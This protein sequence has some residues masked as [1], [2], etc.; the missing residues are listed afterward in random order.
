MRA[1][2]AQR[3]VVEG[4]G[5]WRVW[6]RRPGHEPV[7]LTWFRGVPTSIG[8][9]TDGDPYG[10]LSA[11]LTF[12]KVTIF[13]RLGV[14]E[15]SWAAPEVDFDIVWDGPLPAAYPYERF[16][17]EGFS[18]PF[19]RS[20]DGGLEVT[21]V[22]AAME[23]D[24]FLAKPE[25]PSQPLPY[26]VA[27]ARQWRGRPS[28]RLRQLK[29]EFPSWWTT[30]Y[31]PK[32]KERAPYIP[33]GVTPGQRWTG[34]LTRETGS[35]DKALTSYI[36]TMLTSMYTDRG[37]WT[38]DLRPGRRPVLLH[39]DIVLEA[40]P[41]TVV[42][43][44]LTPG[45]RIDLTEDWSQTA[46]VVYAQTKSLSGEAFSGMQVVDD[47]QGTVYKPAAALRQVDPISDRNTWLQPERMRREQM[48]QLQ[49]G[50]NALDTRAVAQKHLQQI[51]EPGQSGTVTLSADP[52]M[53]GQVLPRLCIKAGMTLQ[54]RNYN[55]SPDG[56]LVHV[57]QV[58]A[59][60]SSGQVT[61]TVDS[62]FRDRLTVDEVQLRGRDALAVQRMLIGGRYRP[63]LPDDLFPWNYAEG[64][65]YIP[66]SPTY[67]ARRLF[68]D[69]PP[70]V[71]FPWE[72]W[73]RTRPPRSAS[74]KSSYIRIAPP[75]AN[76]DQNWAYVANRGGGRF[77]FPIRLAQAGQIRL[78]QLAAYDADGNVMRV[79]F[80]FSLYYQ[81]NVNVQN[82]P[83]MPADRV[84]PPYAA[85][86]RYPFFSGAWETYNTDGSKV[87]TEIP[88]S[89]ST[90]G[91]I[92]G[93]GTSELQAG[94]W[95]GTS[96]EDPPTGL[97]VDEDPFEFDLVGPTPH[98]N[99]Y[100]KDDVSPYAGYVYC[101]I[102]CDSHP[103][104]EAVYFM[105]RMYRAE[106]GASA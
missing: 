28:L 52:L 76:A 43:D 53:D 88:V 32:P 102:Y 80:H 86:Q 33:T 89:V 87:G 42:V 31:Q 98:I 77:G 49:D 58:S 75:S 29:V 4:A 83:K 74:W 59:S 30:F 6:A 99:P 5:V 61:L 94:H 96:A 46:N 90:A 91:L 12:P 34:L 82:M 100:S 17:W 11:S 22:G 21:L 67:N 54:V 45:V 56:V 40:G 16:V 103:A 47:G 50:L 1:P 104:D 7:E 18:L 20:S 10:P 78:L 72:E 9:W 57:T 14:G 35:F 37:R 2:A 23:L 19:R 97:L 36:Q 51:A 55:G 13:D 66:S 41:S 105:G 62:K 38:L 65:G 101:M 3:T 64:S 71:T 44:P 79:P 106:P 92:R 15:L 39:R 81:R 73:T 60:H 95:P 8:D 84:V 69:M 25:Y 63:V 93:W 48:L 70:E 27:I 24:G 26:E 68:E 85:G